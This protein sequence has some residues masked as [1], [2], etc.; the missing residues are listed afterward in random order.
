MENKEIYT[1]FILMPPLY[2]FKHNIIESDTNT[3]ACS[4]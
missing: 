3:L 2:F 1:V 4:K